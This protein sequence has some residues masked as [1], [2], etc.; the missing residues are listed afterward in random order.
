M[1]K[2]LIITCWYPPQLYP[3]FRIVGLAKY[4]PEFG[5]QPI[6]LT[7]SLAK[8][9]SPQFRVIETPYRDVLGF[10]KRLFGFNLNENIRRQVNERFSVT[11]KNRLV[12]FIFTKV[13]ELLGYP[14]LHRGWKP[15]AVKAGSDLLQKEDVDVVLSSSMPVI[16]HIIA[17]E[18]KS[19]YRIPWLADLRDLWTQNHN[20]NYGPLRKLIDKRLEFRTLSMADVLVTTSQPMAEK[21]RTLHKEKLVYT[22]TNGFDP[23]EVNSPPNNLAAKFTITYTGNIYPKRQYPSKLFVALRD[24]VADGT[25]NPDDIEVRFY[26]RREEWVEREINSYGLSGIIK[27]NGVVVR[28]IALQKQ[29]ESQLLLLLKWEDP[30]VPGVYTGKIFEYLAARRP[31]LA[32]GGSDDVVNELLDKTKAGICSVTVDHIKNTLEE[33]YKEYKLKGEVTYRGDE[34]EINKYSHR[35]MARKFSEILDQLTLEMIIER[36]V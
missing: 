30:K 25:L 36:K 7:S 34:S 33:L 3:S 17:K 5:W 11:S 16:S 26:G 2:I 23:A 13:G 20:Y 12:D 32:T 21:L 14:D 35:E 15:F 27:Q 9:L 29:R 1:K 4:L 18:L 8:K 31:V 22:I 6:I 10:W 28:E 19:R 24:L